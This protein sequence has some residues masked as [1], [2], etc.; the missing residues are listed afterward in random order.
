MTYLVGNIYP[1]GFNEKES[2]PMLKRGRNQYGVAA[3]H[4]QAGYI[5]SSQ[6]HVCQRDNLLET[7]AITPIGG[8][9]VHS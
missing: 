7:L 9:V 2:A 8:V 3:Y 4:S 5:G 6:E 1:F